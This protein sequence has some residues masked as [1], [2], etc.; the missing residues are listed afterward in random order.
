MDADKNKMSIKFRDNFI[1]DLENSHVWFNLEEFADIHNIDGAEIMAI[2][3]KN[4]RS[5]T[6]NLNGMF[7]SSEVYGILYVR[8]QEIEGVQAGQALRL[9]Q[10][11]YAVKDAR[12]LQDQVWRI[13][14]TA[15]ES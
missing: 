15:N 5:T 10:R 9:D 2:F 11:L 13:E 14:L 4:H 8:T 7:N 12:K 1:N 6:I 3:V